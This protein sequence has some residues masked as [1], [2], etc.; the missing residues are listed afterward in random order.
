MFFNFELIIIIINIFASY[1]K[2]QFIAC[3]SHAGYAQT[4]ENEIKA[5]GKNTDNEDLFCKKEFNCCNI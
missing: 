4:Q 5:E 3:R 2:A 1:I